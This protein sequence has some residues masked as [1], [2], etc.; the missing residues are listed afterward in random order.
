MKHFIYH[1]TLNFWLQ[2]SGGT[3]FKNNAKLYGIF[4]FFTVKLCCRSGLCDLRKGRRILER[5][6]FSIKVTELGMKNL[7]PEFA[8]MMSNSNHDLK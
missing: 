6:F 3:L 2:Y 1:F 7:A 8:D 4:R 5:V